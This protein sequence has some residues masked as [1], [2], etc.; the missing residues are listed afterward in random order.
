[1]VPDRQRTVL[2]AAHDRAWR[3]PLAVATQWS[4]LE[5]VDLR[6]LAHTTRGAFWDILAARGITVLVTR[7]YEHLVLALHAGRRGPRVSYLPLPHPSGLVFDRKRG[8]V[9]VASTRNPNQIVDLVPAAAQRRAAGRGLRPLPDR[10]LLPMRSRFLPGATYLHDLALIGGGLY[11]NAVGQNAVVRIGDRGGTERVWW[12]RAIETSAGPIFERN[13]LQL[14]SIAAGR[15]LRTSYFTAS[16]DAV[17]ALRPGHRRFAVDRRGVV[18]SG[19]TREPVVRGLTRP[20]SARLRDGML[21]VLN[22]GYGEV[23]VCDR[24]RFEPIARPGGWTRG[25]A[26]VG[27]IAIVGTSRVLRRFAHYAPGVDPARSV[28]GVHLLEASSGRV[29]G[30]LLWPLGNQVFG[31]EVV[32]ASFTC[33]FPCAVGRRSEAQIRALFFGFETRPTKGRGQ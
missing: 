31:I 10:P 6:L 29:L 30:S 7:E 21:W 24:G 19:A 20:H 22:S 23:G 15:T 17:G 14:N 8:V 13:H 18:F 16:T 2:H 4:P 9:H 27:S 3:S 28:C 26:F 25:L 12:P 32:P 11:G 33:G 5:S 1:M